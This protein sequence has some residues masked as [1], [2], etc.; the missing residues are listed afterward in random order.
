MNQY[1]K[2]E[3]LTIPLTIS[4]EQAYYGCTIP[5]NIERWV[6]IGETKITE[7]ETTDVKVYEGID[8]NEIITLR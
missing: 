6:M 2:P 4:L 7:E 3:P 5:I 1:S 8:D